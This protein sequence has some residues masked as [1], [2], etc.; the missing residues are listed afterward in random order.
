MSQVRQRPRDP[1]APVDD[2]AAGA[3]A[4]LVRLALLLTLLLRVAGVFVHS[5]WL[6]GVD[7]FRHLPPLV[8][9]AL[10]VLAALG[11]VPRV[12]QALE[13]GLGAA[14]RGWEKAGLWGDLAVGVIV[15]LVLLPLHDD[16]R[17]TGDSVIRAG[18]LKLSIAEA[19][20]LL[21]YAFPLDQVVNFDLPR[22]LWLQGMGSEAALQV[23]GA[24]MGGLFAW[25]GCAFLRESGARGAALA[26]AA[27]V[28][29]GAGV[30]AHFPG[31]D[32]FGPLVLGLTLAAKGA[33]GLAR[34]GRG[35]VALAAGAG[36]CL[37]SHRSGYLVLPAA[38]WVLVGSFRGTD[39]ARGRRRVAVAALALLIVAAAMLPRTVDVVLHY[40]RQTHLPGGGAGSS[41]GL[42]AASLPM[43]IADRLNV[44]SFLVPLWLAGLAAAWPR[45][46]AG[47]AKRRRGRFQ[48]GPVTW[49]AL[50]GLGLVLVAVRPGGGW[51]RDW[52][53]A[54]PA[55]AAVALV[56]AFL[57]ARLWSRGGAAHTLAPAVTLAL[58]TA[59]AFWG[60]S[61]SEWAG[62]RRAESLLGAR[63]ALDITVRA[64]AWDAL[65]M[66]A[67]KTL[68]LELAAGYFERSI[69]CAPNPRLFYQLGLVR[70]GLGQYGPARAAFT[71]GTVLTPLNGD[72][73]LGLART[74]LAEGD[75]LGAAATLDS[76]LARNPGSAE[77]RALRDRLATS[78]GTDPR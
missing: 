10:V 26:A 2:P 76:A 19:T 73:W 24:V 33:V 72:P 69:E 61:V 59:V 58:A 57:L 75:T 70:L 54:V 53:V 29:L 67:H 12:G 5:N 44:V 46:T 39:D 50:G 31:Y 56:T 4:R 11:F 55:A 30:L 27:L 66:W 78:R 25:A 47:A 51:A 48:L 3:A 23:V 37:L 20:R 9:G 45:G 28:L 7:T 43:G 71:R 15:A 63:P 42:D 13:R 17:F 14:G 60:V 74:A 21:H 65:G 35:L 16:L 1:D 77:I 49:L 62:L 41:R 18:L 52:D 6:W 8:A 32:K 22:A 36:L 40:D 64:N 34:R 38:A 68:R